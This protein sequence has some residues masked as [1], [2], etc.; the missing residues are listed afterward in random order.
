MR[1]FPVSRDK[2]SGRITFP[3]GDFPEAILNSSF[4]WNGIRE[5]FIVATE[6]DTLNGICMLLGH[7]LTGTAQVFGDIRTLLESG[8][9]G[10]GYRQKLTGIAQNGIYPFY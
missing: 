7:L 4:D 9:R 5:P 8:S 10:T 3:N 1:L 6:N 2:D